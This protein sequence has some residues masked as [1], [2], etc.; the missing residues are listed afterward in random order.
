M[1]KQYIA[2]I[3]SGV[4]G[5]SVL[6]KLVK[7]FPNQRFLYYGDNDNAPY[8][9]RSRQDLLSLAIHNIDIIKQFP[10]KAIVLACN[11]LSVNLI[12]EISEYSNLKTF[13][14]FPPVEH[15]Q[16]NGEKTILLATQRTCDNYKDNELVTTVGFYDLAKQID[17]KIFNVNTVNFLSC[18]YISSLD[19]KNVKKGE[20][21]NLII[22]CTHYNFIKNQIINHFR[23]Q[24]VFDGTECLLLNL[25][26]YIKSGKRLDNY[27]QN[28]VLFIGKNAK[29]NEKVFKI[30]G[31]IV[32]KNDIFMQKI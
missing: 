22:G 20:F 3:D 10:V 17:K 31:Q 9:N 21:F 15:C 24:K 26:K 32:Q 8:G 25:S 29:F 12:N 13:G 19:L 6:N 5:I 27:L 1:N 18:E 28:Q 4:G 14:V 23:P 7:N 11:T 16:A 30:C 2:V